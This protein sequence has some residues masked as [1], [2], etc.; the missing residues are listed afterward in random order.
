[1]IEAVA[2]W[3]AVC[4]NCGKAHEGPDG[5][6]AWSDENGAYEMATGSDWLDAGDG[7]LYCDDCRSDFEDDEDE[8]PSWA[9]DAQQDERQAIWDRLE[10]GA[11]VVPDLFKQPFVGNPFD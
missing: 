5:I 2:F 11:K 1:M 6:E 8:T 10:E 4:D 7:L 3:K 9:I